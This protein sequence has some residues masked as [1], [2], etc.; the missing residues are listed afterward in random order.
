MNDQHQHRLALAKLSLE[1]LSVGDAF[2]EQFFEAANQTRALLARELPPEPWYYTDDTAMALGIVDVLA[3]SE[4]LDADLLA[5]TFAQNYQNEPY[6]GY[7]AAIHRVLGGIAAGQSWRELSYSQFNGEGSM[8]NGAAMRVAPLGAYF[9]DDTALLI[10]AADRSAEVT[11]AH[12]E[13]RAGAVA[14]ALAA[15][16]VCRN[17][18]AAAAGGNGRD[19]LAFVLKHTPNGQT[20]SLIAKAMDLPL[21]SSPVLAAL[22]LGNGSEIT[23]PDTVPFALWCAARHL[24]DFE[25]SMWT[26]ISG[27]GDIDTNCAI[28]GG[29]VALATGIE[30]IPKEWL[31]MREMLPI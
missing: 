29:I 7:G 31:Q 21:R 1:G 14:V 26:T 24:D 3:R 5:R 22:A 18:D 12:P 11:H 17:R 2:G 27:L 23:A 9:A 8:G 6:R 30:G 20:H 4:G 16:W 28:V 13:G 25:E 10:E 15:A 19:M